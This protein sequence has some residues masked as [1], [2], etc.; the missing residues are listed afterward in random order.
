MSIFKPSTVDRILNRPWWVRL[1]MDLCR[2]DFE[3]HEENIYKR[4]CKKCK[5][6]ECLMS[7]GFPKLGKPSQ[8]WNEFF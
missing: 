2:H 4:K 8:N 1:K 5:R 7:D 3:I 6:V